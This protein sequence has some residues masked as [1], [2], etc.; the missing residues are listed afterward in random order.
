MLN[1]VE[2]EIMRVYIVE[3]ESFRKLI[4]ALSNGIFP[5]SRKTTVEKLLYRKNK[6]ISCI[7]KELEEV[8]YI[9]TTTNI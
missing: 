6:I 3:N 9:C 8:E 2:D 7:K 4:S 5:P 1:F